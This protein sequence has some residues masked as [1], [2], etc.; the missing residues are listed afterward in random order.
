MNFKK[1]ASKTAT[2]GLAAALS[3]AVVIPG[4]ANAANIQPAKSQITVESVA[5][6][7]AA[8]KKV[9]TH[10]TTTNVNLRKG[11]GVKHSVIT[12]VKKG[13]TVTKTGKK[14]GAWIQVKANGKTGWLNGT[15]VKTTTKTIKAESPKTTL[16]SDYITT[17]GLNMRKSASASSALVV[18][19]PKNTGVSK[20]GKTSGS[21]WQIESGPYTGW[22]NSSYLKKGK[23][24]EMKN[25]T[26]P[27]SNKVTL[28]KNAVNVQNKLKSL[29]G[30]SI[31]SIGGVRA[32]S[33]GHSA[34]LAIDV[35]IKN[36]KTKAGKASGDKIAD[37]LVKN[38]KSLNIDYLIWNDKIW[39]G[40][41]TGWQPYSTSGKYGTQFTNN[42]N[43]TTKHLDHVHVEVKR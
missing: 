9:T 2:L 32:G 40:Q 7:A 37:Y 33:V 17:T 18:T 14:S 27:T 39:L 36:Y 24:N 42:W 8:S 4:A 15:Y 20:T 25:V 29:Y 38:H 21:W 3:A 6:I 23:A 34:G 5:Q 30:S 41:Y 28:H 11:A 1:F 22:V 19:M 35:M 43:D 13:A 16:S 10:S 26:P 12:I 31:S